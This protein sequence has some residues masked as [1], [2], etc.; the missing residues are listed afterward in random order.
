MGTLCRVPDFVP[1]RLQIRLDC[2][3]F[4][5]LNRSLLRLRADV[6]ISFKH[7]TANVTRKCPNR[8]L[9]HVRILRKPRDERVPHIVRPVASASSFAG[10]PPGFAPRTHRLTEI[11]AVEHWQA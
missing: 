10:N 9:A 1:G 6:A 2:S 7:L 11:G 8:L 4:K 3:L 5:R